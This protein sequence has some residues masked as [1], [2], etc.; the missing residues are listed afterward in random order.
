MSAVGCKDAAT[1]EGGTTGGTTPQNAGGTPTA[2]GRPEPKGAGVPV[3]G[4]TIKIGLVASQ[5]GELRPWGI[6]CVNGVKLA[7]EEIN[8]AGGINGKKVQIIIGD[9]NSK[10][11]AGKTAAQK[12]ASDGA[13]ALLGEVASGITKQMSTVAIDKGIPLVAVGATRTDLTGEANN[14]FRV[15]YTDA[16]QGPVMAYFAFNELKLKK[17]AM[18]TDKSQPYSTGLS[19]SFAA[20]FKELGGEIVTEELYESGQTQF[21]AQLTNVKA[22]NPDGIFMSGYF[23]EA[24]PMARQIRDIGMKD[25]KLFGG[26]G[27]DSTEI[28]SGGGEAIIG[29]YFCNHYNNKEPREEVKSFLDK[30]KA[31]YKAEPGTTMGA[32][33][34]DAAMLLFD[35]IKRMKGT[36]SKA[37]TAAL[38]DTSDFKG[39]SGAITLKGMNGNPPKRALVVMVSKEGQTF[40]KA[41]EASEIK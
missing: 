31:K 12:L 22:K 20:K 34:Y 36:D 7:E 41:Y 16:F 1:T 35:A 26:D 2:G 38:E 25:V 24:G 27:W 40:A 14:L 18:M 10:P 6:D 28:V 23:P 4:D 11:E 19:E 15:C 39:V 5:T 13:V 17:V 21:T 33:G 8:A 30:W 32:L 3:A 37:I 9:S 29:S